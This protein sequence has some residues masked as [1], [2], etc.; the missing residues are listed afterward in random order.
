MAGKRQ[1]LYNTL[2][3]AAV[4]S[5]GDMIDRRDIDEALAEVPG[6]SPK[7]LLELPLGGDFSLDRHLAEIQRHYLS[8]ALAEAEGVQRRAA[9]LLGYRNY[10]TLAAQLE[11]FGIKKEKR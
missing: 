2:V 6:R 8:R 5:D 3:Q 10:Q 9:E 7:D 11:R 4:M 1:V